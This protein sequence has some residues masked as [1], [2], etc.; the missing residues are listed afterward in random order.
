MRQTQWTLNS[1]GLY[2]GNECLICNEI[3][4]GWRIK[5]LFTPKLIRH[6]FKNISHELRKA[7]SKTRQNMKFLKIFVIFCSIHFC[8]PI[9]LDRFK[10]CTCQ[11]SGKSLKWLY[12][13]VKTYKKKISTLNSSIEKIRKLDDDFKVFIWYFWVLNKSGNW[14]IS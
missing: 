11:S 4:C 2:S 14:K 8:I 10:A 7:R 13:Y 9:I 3:I 12:C 1:L 6:F 5:K